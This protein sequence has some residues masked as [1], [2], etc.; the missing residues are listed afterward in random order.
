MGDK[1]WEERVGGQ[2]QGG[3]GWG[4]RPGYAVE[5]YQLFGI[6]DGFESDKVRLQRLRLLPR[7]S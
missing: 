7:E 3:K 5:T 6:F 2:G 4:T 1:A